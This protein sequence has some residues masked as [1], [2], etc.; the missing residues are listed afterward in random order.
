M[1]AGAFEADR[2]PE[3]FVEPLRIDV[4]RR[5]KRHPQFEYG[6]HH[7][8]GAALARMQVNAVLTRLV[9]NSPRSIGA[10]PTLELDADPASLPWYHGTLLR[11][12]T[13]LPVRW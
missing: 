2:D 10:F 3:V 4:D 12:P 11:R 9:R 5:G 7:C 1:H 6:M 13:S 8:M